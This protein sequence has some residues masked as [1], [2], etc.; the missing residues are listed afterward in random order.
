MRAF[1][2]LNAVNRPE[3]ACFGVLVQIETMLAERT[4]LHAAD[5]HPSVEVILQLLG[6]YGRWLL[7]RIRNTWSNSRWLDSRGTCYSWYAQSSDERG[8]ENHKHDDMRF[9]FRKSSIDKKDPHDRGSFTEY[10]RF[11]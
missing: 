2:L 9:V 1:C 10:G 7:N 4:S 3:I 6:S 5:Q 11:T 8:H